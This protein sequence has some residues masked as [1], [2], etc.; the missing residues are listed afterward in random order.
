MKAEK[1]MQLAISRVFVAIL[2]LISFAGCRESI[3]PT[4]PTL[5]QFDPTAAVTASEIEAADVSALFIGN[6]HSL[7]LPEL[8]TEIYAKQQPDKQV[9]FRRSSYSGFLDDHAGATATLNALESGPWEYVILQ[10]QK[11]STSGKFDYPTEGAI[12]LSDLASKLNA[13]ILMYP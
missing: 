10:A 13:K 11:Y 3:E 12:K 4:P 7:A 8:L 1:P 5:A 6:S 2:I 9:V